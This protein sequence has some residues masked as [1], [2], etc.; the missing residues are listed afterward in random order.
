MAR[1]TKQGI[2]YFPIDT[3]FDDNLQLLV[4]EVGAEGLGI[5]LTI[6]QAIYKANGYYIKH[7]DKFPLKIKQKCFANA[8]NVINV[9]ENAIKFEI[10][11]VDMYQN[12][13]ILTSRGIQ[14]RYF[15][16]SRAKKQIEIIPNYMLVD[17]SN[18]E[19]V[20]IVVENGV[21]NGRNATKEEVKEEVKE[22]K[23]S[24]K[25]FIVPSIEE[26][27]SYC[28]ERNNQINPD[29][30]IDHYESN[31][32]MVGK[33]KMKDWKAA[34]RTWEQRNYGGNN[35]RTQGSTGAIRGKTEESQSDGQPYP[36]DAEF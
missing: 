9:V 25:R 36:V 10:F 6:W 5:L 29:S 19:N 31:S 2:D 1:P 13:Q 17:V 28:K 32:W 12:H 8:E 24:N 33:N 26:I 34:I 30:F 15:T 3:E 23:K 27:K 14:K 4:A 20:V 35:G 16:A 21:L 7:D 11:N 18:V 22:E